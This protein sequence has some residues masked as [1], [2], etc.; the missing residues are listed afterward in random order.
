MG[1]LY[2]LVTYG[3]E[4]QSGLEDMP[5]YPVP[6]MLYQL[7][8]SFIKAANHYMPGNKSIAVGRLSVNQPYVFVLINRE[9]TII[10]HSVRCP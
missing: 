2:C 9:Y 10:T 8:N 6:S 1:H 4:S 3:N 7:N 5:T